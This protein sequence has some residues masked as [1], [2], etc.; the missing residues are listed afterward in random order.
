MPTLARLQLLVD[1]WKFFS[2]HERTD[3]LGILIVAQVQRKEVIFT[4]SSGLEQTDVRGMR[5]L[6]LLQS[7]VGTW[8][9]FSGRE[10]MDVRQWKCMTKRSRLNNMRENLFYQQDLSNPNK[11]P[12]RSPIHLSI[13]LE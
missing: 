12:G 11:E 9:F 6:A 1:I 8:T 3:V 13:Q 7:I 10:K 2:G 4:F 5:T